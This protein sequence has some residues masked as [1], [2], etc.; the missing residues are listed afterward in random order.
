MTHEGHNHVNDSHE[1]HHHGLGAALW[2]TAAFMLVELVGGYISNSLALMAD[3]GHMASDVMALGLAMVAQR[4]A[5][6]PAHAGMTYGYG[7]VKVL[8]A[9]VNGLTLWFLSGWIVWEAIGRLAN[10]PEVQGTMVL[11]IAT[12]GLFINLI[13]MRW[14]HGSHDLNTR[15]AY[16]HVLGDALGSVAAMVSGAVILLTGWMPIDPILSF[17]VAAVLVWGGWR[18]VRETTLELMEALPKGVDINLVQQKLLQVKGVVGVH[19][20]HVWKLPN[21]KLAA[22]AHIQVEV[23]ED[24]PQTLLLLQ[25]VLAAYH[26]E[27]VTL[28]AELVCCSESIEGNCR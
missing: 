26:V 12:V 27:H 21:A 18:L 6:R 1:G 22:S 28:Q 5:A 9:Q 7:R 11:V 17:F 2:L 25:G 24:W 19:H 20:M 16:W 23:M 15:A 3:A 8:A 14:L 4:I 13:I 10:P